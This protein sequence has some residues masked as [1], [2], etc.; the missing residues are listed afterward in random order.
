[1]KSIVKF[2]VFLV[3][4]IVNA[5]SHTHMNTHLSQYTHVQPTPM[6]ISEKLDRLD[7]KIYKVGQKSVSLS[8][9]TSSIT[10]RIISYKYAT[11]TSN[12]GFKPNHVS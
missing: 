4:H 11:L 10:E 7:L 12:L 1:L 5:D 9:K 2:I 8:T 3:C 6:N